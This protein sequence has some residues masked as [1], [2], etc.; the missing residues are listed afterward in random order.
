MRR[1]SD[2]LGVRPQHAA[3]S[4]PQSLPMNI[5]QFHNLIQIFRMA[6]LLRL[7]RVQRMSKVENQKLKFKKIKIK[8]KIEQNCSACT[9]CSACPRIKF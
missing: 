4:D 2:Q 9:E 6:K 5:A 3:R 1:G 8:I 7:H